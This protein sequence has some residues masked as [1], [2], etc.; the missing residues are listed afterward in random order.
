M[1]LGSTLHHLAFSQQLKHKFVQN[2][3]QEQINP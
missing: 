2:E 1:C 3:I